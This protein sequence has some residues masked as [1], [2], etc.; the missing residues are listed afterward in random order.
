[1]ELKEKESKKNILLVVTNIFIAIEEMNAIDSNSN[2]YYI[3]DDS[4]NKDIKKRETLREDIKQIYPELK[5]Y[6]KDLSVDVLVGVSYITKYLHNVI[7]YV[8]PK[9]IV[10]VEDGSYDYLSDGEEDYPEIKQDKVLYAFRPNQVLS[11]RFKE[12]KPLKVDMKRVVEVYKKNFKCLTEIDKDAV[13]LF[14]TPMKDF[15]YDSTEK[16]IG[17]LERHY[18]GKTVLVKRHPR[19]ERKFNS[20]KLNL[21]FCPNNIPG[22]IICELFKGEKIFEFPSTITFMTDSDENIKIVEYNDIEDIG[23]RNTISTAKETFNFK[24]VDSRS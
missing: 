13:V 17:Y 2:I 14:T 20:D 10:F 8:K 3:I 22:Q 16:I 21:E 6:E 15:D 23:Y 19:D 12:I 24:I 1:M 7:E 9:E 4:Y 18:V 11:K 5:E